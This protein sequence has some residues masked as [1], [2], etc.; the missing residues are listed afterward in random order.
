VPG[1][2]GSLPPRIL[3][4]VCN[5]GIGNAVEALPA[6]D[7]IL[8]HLPGAR[9]AAGVFK[10]KQEQ[11]LARSQA[12]ADVVELRGSMRYARRSL[13]GLVHNVRAMRGFERVLFLY[14]RDRVPWPLRAAAR[15]A[16]ARP[17]Y[18]HGYTYRD[19][20]RNVFSDFPEHV[21][22]QMVTA[23]LLLRTPLTSLS[24]PTIEL[25]SDERRFADD[26]LAAWGLGTAPVVFVNRQSR[27]YPGSHPDWGIDNYVE[28]VRLLAAR[29]L[30]VILNGGGERQAQEFRSAADRFPERSVLLER[31]SPLELAAVIARC[32]VYVGAASGPASLAMALGTPTVTIVGPGDDRYP[33]EGRIGPVWWPRQ[34]CHA[35]LSKVD[36]CHRRFGDACLC[37]R[38]VPVR[39]RALRRLHL[40]KAW[41]KA[42]K[43]YLKA[44][45]RYRRRAV[46]Y[47]CLELVTPAEVADEVLQR[48][49]TPV[50]APAG[51][52]R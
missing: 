35:V 3:V 41:K 25:A 24:R 38:T 27:D 29:G 14:K 45:G 12:I 52:D 23:S 39:K 18:R 26:R 40:W 16:G 50:P 47:P 20:R 22:Y 11:I 36:V 28:L 42:R 46:V 2:D 7:L 33:G 5:T 17:L 48:V 15:L 51:T 43:R 8:T 30:Q 21:F 31:P 6:F 44:R 1:P 10:G 9:V 13:R 49:A 4:V 32:D 19:P 34:P 37:R